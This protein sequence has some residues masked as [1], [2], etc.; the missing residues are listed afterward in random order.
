MFIDIGGIQRDGF[1]A[2]VRCLERDNVQQ[3]FQDGMQTPC[4]DVLR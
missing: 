2:A 4:T 3:A 1:P